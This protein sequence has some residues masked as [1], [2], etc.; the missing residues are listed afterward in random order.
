MDF[1][2]LLNVFKPRSFYS[3][4]KDDREEIYEDFLLNLKINPFSGG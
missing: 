1:Q 3:V 2:F 4:Y